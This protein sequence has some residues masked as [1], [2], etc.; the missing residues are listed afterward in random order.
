M[1]P[2]RQ[3]APE[4]SIPPPTRPSSPDGEEIDEVMVVC[5]HYKWRPHSQAHAHVA[6]SILR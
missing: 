5:S 6:D 2:R 3:A 1:A 4:G